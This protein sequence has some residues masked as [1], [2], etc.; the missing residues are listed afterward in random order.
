[1]TEAIRYQIGMPEHCRRRAAELYEEAFRQ[2]FLPI[3]R[4]R[5]KIIEILADSI[6]PE[7]AV[8]ALEG[9]RLVGLA[10]FYHK[11]NSFT[12]GMSTSVITK[13]LG[14]IRGLWSTALLGILYSRKVTEGELWMDGIVVDQEIRGRGVGTKILEKLSEFAKDSRY[15]TIRLEVIDTNTRARKLYGSQGFIELETQ[16]YPYLKPFFG[17]SASTTMVKE[18]L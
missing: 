11:G 15:E 4:S 12:G 1:M 2:K 16:H 9:D 5:E 17:F 13:H 6:Q 18:F 8:V 14:L 3:V 10:G 7:L